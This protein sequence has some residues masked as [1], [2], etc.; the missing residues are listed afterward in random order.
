MNCE[1]TYSPM[2]NDRTTSS[3]FRESLSILTFAVIR[4]AA[5]LGR[6]P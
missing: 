2:H 6:S 1:L 4:A 5:H 3:G